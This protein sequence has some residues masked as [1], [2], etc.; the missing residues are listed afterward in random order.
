MDTTC[1]SPL[2]ALNLAVTRVRMTKRRPPLTFENAL[3]KVAGL[4]GWARWRDRRRGRAHGAQ[5]V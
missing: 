1:L 3:T 4:I 2:E 5:L